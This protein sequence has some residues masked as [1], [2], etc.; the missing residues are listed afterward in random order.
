M[1]ALAA[2]TNDKY[3][4]D[5]RKW[6]EWTNNKAEVTTIPADPFHIALY[7][8]FIIQTNGT[9]GTLKTVTYGIRWAAGFQSPTDDPFVD[10][11]LKGCKTEDKERPHHRTDHQNV[12]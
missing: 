2:S 6:V 12:S 4:R 9:V 3:G 10:L 8:N 1:S 7:L 11:V 5:W